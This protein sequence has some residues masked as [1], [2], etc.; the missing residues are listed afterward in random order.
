M[1]EMYGYGNEDLERDTSGDYM[2]DAGVSVIAC[3]AGD[4]G[5]AL[6]EL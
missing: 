2:V 4:I 1:F 5:F 6:V 3:H